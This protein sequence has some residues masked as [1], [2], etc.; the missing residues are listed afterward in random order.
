MESRTYKEFDGLLSEPAIEDHHIA[1]PGWLAALALGAILLPAGVVAL[2]M[3]WS[4]GRLTGE[5]AIFVLIGLLG[6]IGCAK[7]FKYDSDNRTLLILKDDGLIYQVEH[8]TN[9]TFET[10]SR[11]E[12]PWTDLRVLSD[13]PYRGIGS[14]RG[15]FIDLDT[16]QGSISFGAP[17]SVYPEIVRTLRKM[18]PHLRS[19]RGND[20]SRTALREAGTSIRAFPWPLEWATLVLGALLGLAGF[21]M[22]TKIISY[23]DPSVWGRGWGIGG[24]DVW[25]QLVVLLPSFWLWA[26]FVLAMCAVPYMRSYR[27]VIVGDGLRFQWTTL[28]LNPVG[29][30]RRTSHVRWRQIQDISF[31]SAPQ[32]GLL[33]NTTHGMIRFGAF[34]SVTFNRRLLDEIRRHWPRTPYGRGQK[35]PQPE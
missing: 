29:F 27:L 13:R 14:R 7:Y 9:D 31:H 16:L 20:D 23:S 4:E 2:A 32:R 33:I 15:S 24:S 3:L 11:M 28:E 22:F 17:A 34:R 1:L 5:A 8:R 19:A 30:A 12:C 26:A 18:A 6:I 25:I 21:L 10:V 35:A